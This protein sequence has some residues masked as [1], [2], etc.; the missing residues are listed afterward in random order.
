M[1]RVLSAGLALLLSA[2]AALAQPMSGRHHVDFAGWTGTAIDG[3]IVGR[4]FDRYELQG[5][6]G[7]TLTIRLNTPH[8]GTYFNVYTPGNGPG[9]EALANSSL[10]GG[11]VLDL[12]QF[13]GTLP[14]TG[15][16]EVVVYMVRAAARRDEAAP[17]SIEFDMLQP[18]DADDPDAALRYYQVRTRSRGGHLNVHT[19]PS[20]DAP[21][22]GRYDNG[23]VLRD[24]GGCEQNGGRDWCE[25]MAY[26]GGLAG[27]VAREF[28]APVSRHH[29]AAPVT[30]PRRGSALPQTP[31]TPTRA[32]I[33]TTSDWFHVHL[34]N[35]GGHLNVHAEPSTASVRVGRLPDG[36]DLRNIG[37]CL[38]SAGRTWCDVMQAGGGVSGW[39]AADY[40]RDGHPPAATMTTRTGAP[41][42]VTTDFAD[43][44]AGGPDW[45][46]VDLNR[47]GSALRVHTRPSTHAPIFARFHDG[48]TLRNADGCRMSEGRRWC[49]VSSVSGDVTGWVA[50][51]FLREGSAPGVATHLPTPVPQAPVAPTAPAAP[52]P[53]ALGPAYDTTGA[54]TCY[55][56]R[57]AGMSECSFGAVHEGSGN[58]YLQITEGGYGGR[59][60]TFEAGVPAYFDQSQAD[61]DITMNVSRQGDLWIVF[62]GDARFEI[63]VSLFQPHQDMGVAT[64]LPLAPPPMEEDATVPGTTFNATAQIP[65]VRDRD[66]AEA[67][68]EAGVV[69]EGGGSGYIQVSWPEGGSRVIYFQNDRPHHYDQAEADGGAE[70]S[71]TRNDRDEFIVFVGEARFVI[72]EALITGG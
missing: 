12:N 23:A 57:D 32:G 18:T 46:Q 52:T 17:Y 38:M 29:G 16:Y 4:D 15:I 9:D 5:V 42:P 13:S 53:Q 30:P 31:P 24:I 19:G 27:F 14:E 49:Y 55:A 43:G 48:A 41:R 22:V 1:N 64:Q 71:V 63:P 66:A 28:L 45:W 50:G 47:S 3:E 65:C 34:A 8:T 40:L 67:M 68:C 21:R 44:M 69:R 35:P 60:I 39:V 37:G 6:A 25:V 62:I 58:G 11:P 26:D 70:M 59:T 20:V 72:P 33:T 2:S 56:D 7:N 51:D 36:A 10:I 54:I 61:G